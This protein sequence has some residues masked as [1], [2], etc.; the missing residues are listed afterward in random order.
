MSVRI[1]HDLLTAYHADFTTTFGSVFEV[2]VGQILG[3]FYRNPG[4]LLSE[5][6]YGRRKERKRSS[7]WTVVEGRINEQRA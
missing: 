3:P 4:E 7:D 2:Y 5:R 1:Y 6:R